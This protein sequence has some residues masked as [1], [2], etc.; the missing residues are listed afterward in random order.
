[1]QDEETKI[2]TEETPVEMPVE[3]TEETPVEET[4][5]EEAKEVENA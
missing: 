1:M 4:P 5:A 2:A 3:A